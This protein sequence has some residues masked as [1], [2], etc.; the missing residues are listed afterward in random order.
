MTDLDRATTSP[1]MAARSRSRLL[2][3]VLA[4]AVIAIVLGGYWFLTQGPGTQFT[5]PAG[6]T[7]A[8]FKG[9]GDQT[10][11]TFTVREGWRIDWQHDSAFAFAIRG[12]RDFGKV[13]DEQGSGSGVTSPVGAGSFHLEITADGP[14]EIKVI[15]GD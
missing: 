11:G 1:G 6:S 15:Q 7:V 9:S 4:V 13:I 2:L 5:S 10:T 12:D 3:A 8:D 14:W